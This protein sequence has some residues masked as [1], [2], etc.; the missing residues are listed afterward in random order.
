MASYTPKNGIVPFCI[1][2]L[3]YTGYRPRKECEVNGHSLECL[4]QSPLV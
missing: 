2:M 1:T 4:I 3:Q